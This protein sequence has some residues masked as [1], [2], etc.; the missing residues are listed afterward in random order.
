MAPKAAGA[1]P[2]DTGMAEAFEGSHNV[3]GLIPAAGFLA[4]FKF[5]GYQDPVMLARPRR[6][7]A[8]CRSWPR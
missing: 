1:M 8:I 7:S 4:A 3:G 5:S 2:A 6:S